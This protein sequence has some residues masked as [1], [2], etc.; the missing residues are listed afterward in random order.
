MVREV[1]LSVALG[2]VPL[3][4]PLLLWCKGTARRS[5][6]LRWLLLQ[7]FGGATV[8]AFVIYLQRMVTMLFG[9]SH[10]SLGSTAWLVGLRGVL[11]GTLV[12]QALL[13]LI[14]LPLRRRQLLR[15]RPDGFLCAM[16]AGAGLCAVE[17]ITLMQEGSVGVLT[18]M[19]GL[20]AIPAGL[21][22]TGLWGYFLFSPEPKP[23][24]TFALAWSSGL[25]LEAVYDHL[26]FE[27]GPGFAVALLPL[28][29]VVVVGSRAIVRESTHPM[30]LPGEARSHRLS[31]FPEPPSLSD[32]GE[33][34]RPSGHRIRLRWIVPGV[35]VVL[36]VTL[37]ALAS[38]VVLGNRFGVDFTRAN[39]ADLHANSPLLLLGT[40]VLL[41]FPAAGY[42]L[43]RASGAETVIESAI[44]AGL[45]IL[46]ALLLVSMAEPLAVVFV[47]AVSPVAFALA[48]TGAWWAGRRERQSSQTL[49]PQP[50][51]GASQDA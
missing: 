35:F 36:G 13:V 42:L 48:C 23:Y 3:A 44:S 24:K 19:R 6:R 4:P 47:L 33:A 51:E 2:L 30:S 17:T 32:L 20:L 11:F 16:S 29:A 8:A 31:V 45:C 50:S 18:V 34:L 1:V 28:L 37:T 46:G 21:F 41:A 5:V 12:S 9:W 39:E 10:D 38:A 15:S 26:L 22:S 43:T 40:A 49:E 7:M 27:R 25:M 14:V